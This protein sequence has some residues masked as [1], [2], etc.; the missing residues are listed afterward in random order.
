MEGLCFYCF[1]IPGKKR[2]LNFMRDPKLAHILVATLCVIGNPVRVT[3]CDRHPAGT[4][5][6]WVVVTLADIGRLGVAL[7]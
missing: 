6:H 2:V 4:P 3:T 1:Q 7:T 5:G